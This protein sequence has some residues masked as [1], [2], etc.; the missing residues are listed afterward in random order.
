VDRLNWRLQQAARALA[1]FKQ[2]AFIESPSMIEWD[3]ANQGF[4][5]TTE[6]YRKAARVTLLEHFGVDAASP[7]AVIRAAAQNGLL[8]EPDAHGHG[9]NRRSKSY[10]PYLQ[11]SVGDNIV[12]AFAWTC[13]GA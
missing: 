10:F 1:I 8:S 9:L 6:A 13:R 2:L 3:A 12:C 5:Y 7:K 11:R 4:E